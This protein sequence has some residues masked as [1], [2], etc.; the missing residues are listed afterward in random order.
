MVVNGI[1]NNITLEEKEKRVIII[2]EI[3]ERR[4]EDKPH[5]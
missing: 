1:I 5:K 2:Q 3:Q 4:K